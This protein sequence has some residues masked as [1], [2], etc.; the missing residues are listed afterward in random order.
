MIESY[1]ISGEPATF[2]T[3]KE[4]IW[5]ETLHGELTGVVPGE[6]DGVSLKFLLPTLAPNGHPL[7]IDNLCEPVFSVLS[8]KLGWFGSKRSNIKYWNA[9]KSVAQNTGVHIQL[10]D[11]GFEVYSNFVL[12]F[13]E[14]YSGELP[15][16]AR[17]KNF[18][19]WCEKKKIPSMQHR[20]RYCVK[21]EFGGFASNIGDIATGKVKSII[22]CLVPVLGGR[23]GAPEDW[24][25]D[26]LS[27]SKGV[28]N[29]NQGE[30]RI[31]IWGEK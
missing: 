30:V 13:D 29:L 16:N 1:W 19:A 21:I 24:R 8:G 7:D 3:K 15:Q 6:C 27:V 17:N 23:E 25:I 26:S 10:K 9:Y 18:I 28:E 22:D 2:A 11:S 14:I 4:K 31:M 12:D 20:E 5:K